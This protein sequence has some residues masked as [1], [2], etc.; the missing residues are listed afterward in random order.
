MS[1]QK[2]LAGKGYKRRLERQ[3]SSIAGCALTLNIADLT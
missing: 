2:I 3:R 1:K